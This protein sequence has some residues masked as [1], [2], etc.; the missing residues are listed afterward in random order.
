M[1]MVDGGILTQKEIQDIALGGTTSS[2]Q[3]T[4]LWDVQPQPGT[5][6]QAMADYQRNLKADQM[7]TSTKPEG[8]LVWVNSKVQNHM[9]L[10]RPVAGQRLKSRR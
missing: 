10:G 2:A 4:Q 1:P 3:A 5:L 6:S 8:N 9:L 7:G